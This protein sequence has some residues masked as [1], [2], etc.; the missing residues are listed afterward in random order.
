MRTWLSLLMSGFVL[1]HQKLRCESV[2]NSNLR[3]CVHNACTKTVKR[4]V[5][6]TFLLKLHVR[7][8][9]VSVAWYYWKMSPCSL[10]ATIFHQQPIQ[11]IFFKSNVRKQLTNGNNWS[12]STLTDHTKS[13]FWRNYSLFANNWRW[14][15]YKPFVT[16]SHSHHMM[17]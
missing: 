5:Y 17:S 9:D 12:N 14:R 3:T 7:L 4:F 11:C 15:L 6:P 8:Q 16:S 10:K 1:V 2:E 13:N